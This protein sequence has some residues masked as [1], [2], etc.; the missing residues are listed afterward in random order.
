MDNNLDMSEIMYR[1][2][3]TEIIP[4]IVDKNSLAAK[5]SLDDFKRILKEEQ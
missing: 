4:T 1:Y 3:E 2:Y 5:I